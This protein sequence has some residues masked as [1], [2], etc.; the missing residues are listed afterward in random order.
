MFVPTSGGLSSAD[1]DRFRDYERRRHDTLAGSYNAFF[2]AVTGRAILPML[3]AA[4]VRGAHAVLDVAT[5]P[6]ALA[7]AAQARGCYTV[8]VDLSPGMIEL[9]RRL[10]PE[11]DFRVA[12]VEH[13]PFPPPL[14]DAVL[15][16]FGIGHFPYPES[17]T[18]ECARVLRR[19]GRLALS[20]WDDFSRQRIQGLFREAIQEIGVVPPPD[21]P[22]SHTGPR[23]ADTAALTAL[24]ES[25]GLVDVKVEEHR[26]THLVADC[27]ALW[28]GGLGSCAIT[29]A[30]ITHQTAPTQAKIRAALER[31]A[32]SYRTPRGL[33]LPVAFRIA[34]GRK[35]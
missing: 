12:D 9:A 5:G 10:H 24:L 25:A 33:E 35:P 20:W 7:A 14:F 30:A 23:F 15:C 18:A 8:G 17:A 32:A 1:A 31:R 4:S 13:L 11:V 29:A 28:Q 21:V 19:T 6:G 27:E 22:L 16:N 2:T 26:G 3:D 34:S